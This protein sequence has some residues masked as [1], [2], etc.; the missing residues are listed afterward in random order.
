MK[1]VTIPKSAIHLIWW[2]PAAFKASFASRVTFGETAAATSPAAKEIADWTVACERAD[3]I[4]AE[5]P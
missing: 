3:E 2:M 4:A 1:A 5:A